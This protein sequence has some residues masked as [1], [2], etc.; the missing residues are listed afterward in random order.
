MNTTSLQTTKRSNPV[1]EC[2][3]AISSYNMSDTDD[4]PEGPSETCSG[5]CTTDESDIEDEDEDDRKFIHV[6]IVDSEANDRPDE[7]YVPDSTSED[8]SDSGNSEQDDSSSDDALDE[9]D[10]ENWKVLEIQ[11]RLE[12]VKLGCSK[13]EAYG[14]QSQ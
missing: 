12:T 1:R 13:S 7:D 8:D 9:D 3:E 5:G 14:I 10:R 2:R 6:E 4:I 11:Q